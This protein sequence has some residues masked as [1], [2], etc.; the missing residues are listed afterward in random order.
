MTTNNSGDLTFKQAG[1]GLLVIGGGLV[2]V[3]MITHQDWVWRG[4]P[5][6]GIGY[7]FAALGLLLT[8]V[9]VV[10]KA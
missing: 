5:V 2:A 7:V 1:I 9:G 6:I 3:E 10:K 4:I 8:I